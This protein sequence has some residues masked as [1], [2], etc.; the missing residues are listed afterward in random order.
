M[1][2][3]LISDQFPPMRGGVADAL[4]LIL[5]GLAARGHEVRVFAP[6]LPDAVPDPRVERM[7]TITFAQGTGNIVSPFG[8]TRRLREFRPDVVHMHSVGL[9]V[10]AGLLAAKRLKI[11]RVITYH[12]DMS[13]YL[14]LVGLDFAWLRAIVDWMCARYFSGANT[15]T[16]PSRLALEKLRRHGVSRPS[17]EYIPN[18]IDACFSPADKARAKESFRISGKT[19]GLFGRVSREKNLADAIEAIALASKKIDLQIVVIGDGPYR[20]E[21]EM[22]VHRA[23]LESRTHYLGFLSGETLVRAINCCDVIV[24][25]GLAEVQPLAILQSLACG[26]PVIGTNAGGTPECIDEG[27][28][29]FILEPHDIDGYAE[30]IVQLLND[31]AM[32]GRFAAAAIENT[33]QFSPENVCAQY[34]TVFRSAAL[35]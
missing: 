8:L 17:M 30:R 21:F 28:T 32:R 35:Q 7:P 14:Y 18:P 12:G 29:G 16:A 23:G 22:L 13:D 25:T 34:E 10:L 19:I 31:D 33:K 3:A 15:V 20:K 1:K 9:L 6:D 2:I 27:A 4:K 5:D 26:V 11:P 24:S